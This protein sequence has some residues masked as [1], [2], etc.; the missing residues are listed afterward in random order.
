M[1]LKY[2]PSKAF[3]HVADSL[4]HTALGAAF[5]PLQSDFCTQRSAAGRPEEIL[6]A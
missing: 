3:P 4:N 2:L 1:S 5:Q 6:P